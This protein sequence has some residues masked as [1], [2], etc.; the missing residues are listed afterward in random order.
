M[1]AAMIPVMLTLLRAGDGLTS[2]HR[3]DRAMVAV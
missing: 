2:I 1:I 3:T